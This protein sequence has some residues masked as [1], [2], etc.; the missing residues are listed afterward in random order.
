[1]RVVVWG[2][3]GLV[4]VYIGLNEG[5]GLKLSNRGCIADLDLMTQGKH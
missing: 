4:L 3:E 5:N 2:G 1:M